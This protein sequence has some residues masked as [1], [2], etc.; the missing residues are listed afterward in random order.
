[1]EHHP[2]R[3]GDIEK[4][5][6]IKAAYETLSDEKKRQQYD[7]FGPEGVQDDNMGGNQG[8]GNPFSEDIF[9]QFFGGGAQQRTV[10]KTDTIHTRAELTLEEIFGGTTKDLHFMKQVICDSCDGLGATSKKGIKHC[11]VCNGTGVVT[12]TRQMGPFMQQV[13][14]ECTACGGQGKTISSE[15]KCGT[16]DGKKVVKK[17]KVLEVKIKAGVKHGT[18][19]FLR[20]QA[21]QHPDM[22]P[23]DIVLTV[24]QKKHDLFTCTGSDLVY[25]HK[26]TLAEALTGFKFPLNN[27]DGSTLVLESS[28]GEVISPGALKVVPGAGMPKSSG[29]GSARGD[30]YLMFD[31]VMPESVTSEVA[32]KLSELL[33]K[34][35]TN[36]LPEDGIPTSPK[37]A[38]RVP[39][40]LDLDETDEGDFGSDEAN[41]SNCRQM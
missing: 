22:E 34:P 27:V 30:L 21:D 33:P 40:K 19:L 38:G 1:M 11:H 12:Q 8:A 20:G 41:S 13:Q 25:K 23:G 35:E 37:H 6:E 3:G 26:L 16:C 32:E 4:F 18:K 17:K 24:L 5:K 31:V 28:D 29:G 14:S 15:Y 36:H 39:F 9:S 10:R 7:Q 2:D